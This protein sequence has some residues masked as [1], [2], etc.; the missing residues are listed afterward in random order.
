M[1]TND[2]ISDETIKQTFQAETLEQLE[3]MSAIFLELESD[4]SRQTS[5][6]KELFRIAHSIKGSSG[7]VNL[8]V[9]KEIMHKIENAF[10]QVR[11][12][13]ALLNQEQIS[14]L[15]QLSQVIYGYVADFESWENPQI[16]DQWQVELDRFFNA[17][18]QNAAVQT[19]EPLSIS[20]QEEQEIAF[21]QESNK[22]VYGIEVEYDADAQMKGASAIIFLRDL[23]QF[24]TIF[25]TVPKKEDLISKDFS[26]LKVILFT[27][28]EFRKEEENGIINYSG[29]G[30]KQVQLRKWT[31]RKK[32]TVPEEKKNGNPVNNS[33]RVDYQKIM[34]LYADLDELLKIKA[35]LVN[36]YNQ[37]NGINNRWVDFGNALF[38][39]EQL[40]RTFQG[41]VLHLGM[42]PAK[43]VFSRFPM[44]IRDIARKTGKEVEV[45]FT[46]E[47]TEIDKRTAELLIDPLTHLIRNAV[48]HGLE[49]TEERI[50]MEKSPTGKI[51]MAATQ[52]GEMMIISV[53]DDGRGLNPEKIRAK[54]VQKGL[55]SES[56]ILTQNDIFQLI[57]KPGFST[58]DRVSEISGR[59]VGL[60]VVENNI[61]SLNGRIDVISR[62]GK[63]TI[64]Q[65][66]VPVTQAIVPIFFVNAGGNYFG[67]PL[68][69][70]IEITTLE[71]NRIQTTPGRMM[72][73]Y[74]QEMI[75]LLDMGEVYQK[76]V[77]LEESEEIPCLII[78]ARERKIGILVDEF[79]GEEKVLLRPLTGDLVDND[80][81]SGIV[82]LSNGETA[83]VL[84]TG[85]L[86]DVNNKIAI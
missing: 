31:Y 5:E 18:P 56:D 61:K 78:Q 20:E 50:R 86:V 3:K 55:I 85:Q 75:T 71:T 6:I 54:A 82:M 29:H 70:V 25:K 12:G 38:R 65:L 11:N 59:G 21:W 27:E 34:K 73:R 15:I 60:D 58:A 76:K 1:N 84:N 14:F 10:D 83:L 28:R 51:V 77:R 22:F 16:L 35:E 37:G 45:V 63:G 26:R 24:G 19:D 48:D 52:E 80:M 4:P 72:A 43:Q 49:S 79:V 8:N 2:F 81:I 47:N 67:I 53:S 64:F 69:E 32:E 42:V 62:P 41:D 57:F 39:M 9:L 36:F 7:V 23:E 17:N 74:S 33:V 44:I 66:K 13:T 46:G 68:T 40:I 30:E